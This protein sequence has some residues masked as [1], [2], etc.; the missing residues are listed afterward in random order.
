MVVLQALDR[1][2]GPTFDDLP[3]L[4]LLK[5]VLQSSPRLVD[6]IRCCIISKRWATLL[7][8]AP[9]WAE[10]DFEGANADCLNAET[11]VLCCRKAQG[12]LRVLDVS[13]DACKEI[14]GFAMYIGKTPLS[15]NRPTWA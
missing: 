15:P 1:P 7:R 11:I 4:L 10:I 5:V 14:E 2:G 13:S 3:I 12:R 9:F 6:R 8:E